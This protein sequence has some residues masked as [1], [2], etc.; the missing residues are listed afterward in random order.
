MSP[1]PE[2]EL[3]KYGSTQVLFY[4]PRRRNGCYPRGWLGEGRRHAGGASTSRAASLRPGVQVSAERCVWSQPAVASSADADWWD[5]LRVRAVDPVRP[6][7]QATARPTGCRR[8]PFYRTT[9]ATLNS[10]RGCGRQRWGLPHRFPGRASRHSTSG[11]CRL[12]GLAILM[13]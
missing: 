9:D 10:I 4:A 11:T 5:A 3:R 1:V 12:R 8:P 13:M 7:G 6:L 2:L